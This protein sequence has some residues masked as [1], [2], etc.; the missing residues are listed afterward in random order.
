MYHNLGFVSIQDVIK[1]TQ[2]LPSFGEY[3]VFKRSLNK[4]TSLRQEKGYI[5]L[6]HRML[7]FEYHHS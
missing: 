1:Q 5:A 7:E 6:A 2:A 3:V 4:L